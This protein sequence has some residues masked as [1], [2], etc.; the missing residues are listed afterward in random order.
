MQQ[1]VTAAKAGDGSIWFV[2][3]TNDIED[4]YYPEGKVYTKG[5]NKGKKHPLAGKKIE[6]GGTLRY[7]LFGSKQGS[8]VDF[9]KFINTFL[10]GT[11]IKIGLT[12]AENKNIKNEYGIKA[13]APQKSSSVI[14]DLVKNVFS[15]TARYDEAMLARE[16]TK[17]QVL[18]YAENKMV[19]DIELA[20]HMMTFG[21][22]MGTVSRRAA[23]VY[24][25]QEGLLSNKD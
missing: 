10:E 25:I 3:G 24:G 5:E 19:S 6:K 14:N 13:L 17:K 8:S 4:A 16:L 12:P 7:Q 18:F 23:Y 20:L 2:D 22:N 1:H 11:G 21:S 9:A 15:F